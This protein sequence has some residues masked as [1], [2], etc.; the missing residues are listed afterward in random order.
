[1]TL[2]DIEMMKLSQW[3]WRSV[4]SGFGFAKVAH[5]HWKS[6]CVI[7]K[8]QLFR[9]VAFGAAI[10]GVVIIG[11]VFTWWAL[12]AL[13]VYPA[14]VARVAWKRGVTSH[15]SWLYSGLLM[16]T[17][18]AELQGIIKYCCGWITGRET[19]LIEYK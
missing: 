17:K 2:H 8:R 13:L 4:R 7:W 16:I 3:W 19:G 11:S 1:M 10:P 9:A 15:S 18:F 12:A 5:L 14:Q 6:P